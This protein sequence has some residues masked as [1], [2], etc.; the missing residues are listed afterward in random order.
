MKFV[1]DR[2]KWRCGHDGKHKLGKGDT[3]LLNFDGYMC[4]L[5]QICEQ[6]GIPKNTL[7]GV[8]FPSN[9]FY[10]TEKISWLLRSSHKY[11]YLE[12]TTVNDNI[13]ITNEE[14]EEKIKH[15]A[16]KYGH[17]VEFIN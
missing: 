4:C 9:L 1:I 15:I 7:I 3:L 6:S 8:N 2:S 12:F 17:E 14:R 5:G 13:T 16:A 10:H 11:P